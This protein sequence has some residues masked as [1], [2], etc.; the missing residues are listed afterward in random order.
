MPTKAQ[1]P[2]ILKQVRASLEKADIPIRVIKSKLNDGWLTII[3]VPTKDGVR[4]SEHADAMS[5]VERELRKGGVDEVVLVPALAEQPRWSA[6]FPGLG[7]C[8]VKP[9]W[10]D[11]SRPP[12]IVPRFLSSQSALRTGGTACFS[13]PGLGVV[14]TLLNRH[15]RRSP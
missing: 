5:A 2:E 3:V 11:P 13:V 7:E 4:A 15:A 6:R 12:S 14:H 10:K 1:V 8:R 9:N